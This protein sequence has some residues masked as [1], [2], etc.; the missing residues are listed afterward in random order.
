MKKE[1]KSSQYATSMNIGINFIITIVLVFYRRG[2]LIVLR[3][4]FVEKE[5]YNFFK[6]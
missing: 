1:K 2:L 3:G 6:D 5:S 4:F